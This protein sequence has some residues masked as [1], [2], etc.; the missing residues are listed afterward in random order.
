MRATYKDIVK[1]IGG[2]YKGRS[3]IVLDHQ[4]RDMDRLFWFAKKRLF[5]QVQ[6]TEKSYP[7]TTFIVWVEENDV[8]VIL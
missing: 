3:G 5:F 2:F 8:E 7:S 1:I 4:L 6:I